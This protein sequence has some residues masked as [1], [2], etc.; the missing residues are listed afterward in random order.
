VESLTRGQVIRARSITK[1]LGPIADPGKYRE[2][3]NCRKG[4]HYVL[5]LL[6]VQNE[7]TA[8][9]DAAKL[10]NEIGWIRKE[11]SSKPS[12]PDRPKKKKLS[13]PRSSRS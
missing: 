11:V 10:L 6:D 5:V 1:L 13:S 2:T 9:L 12:C 8:P 7:K 4:F 3:W